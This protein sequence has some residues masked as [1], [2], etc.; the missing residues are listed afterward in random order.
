MRISTRCE[1]RVSLQ[2]GDS[3]IVAM[4]SARPDGRQTVRLN[5][6]RNGHIV[7]SDH[8][9]R[10][11]RWPGHVTVFS[12]GAAFDFAVPDP[13]AKAAEAEAGTGSMR[14]PMPGLV[15]IVRAAKG[16]AVAKGQPL[17]DPRG[18]EDGAHDRRAA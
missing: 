18:D 10:A 13:F 14:A 15:K 6:A 1:R 9:T 11:A 16:D 12:D 4:V 5:G 2:I 17:L 7:S 3:E 8:A